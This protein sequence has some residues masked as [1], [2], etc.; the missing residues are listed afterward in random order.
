MQRWRRLMINVWSLWTRRGRWSFFA[1]AVLLKSSESF[2]RVVSTHRCIDHRWRFFPHVTGVY[3]LDRGTLMAVAT[4]QEFLHSSILPVFFN[5]GMQ[6]SRFAKQANIF[7]PHA[8]QGPNWIARYCLRGHAALSGAPLSCLPQL[9][10]EG[11]SLMVHT[12]RY[13]PCL[14]TRQHANSRT[15]RVTARAQC[16]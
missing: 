7:N 12:H 11:A 6:L 5:N 9:L 3:E 10:F 13:H 15:T 4:R 1:L 8:E 14:F 16:L 2:C